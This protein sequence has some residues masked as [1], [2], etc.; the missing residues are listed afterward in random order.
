M[1]MNQLDHEVT[2]CFPCQARALGELAGRQS[3]GNLAK[4]GKFTLI[5]SS[6]G[7]RTL[8]KRRETYLNHSRVKNT[9][10]SPEKFAMT[11][12]VTY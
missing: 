3:T 9:V 7:K 8:A 2:T 6:V 5:K 11:T 4:H 1:Q 12:N 10:P